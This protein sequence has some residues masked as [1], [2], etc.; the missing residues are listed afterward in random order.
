MVRQGADAAPVEVGKANK[1]RA[2]LVGSFF[3]T[4]PRRR[5]HPNGSGDSIFLPRGGAKVAARL[6][7]IPL[8]WSGLRS[9]SF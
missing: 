8:E 2:D 7:R 6:E 4:A 1:I 3:L 5:V 9:T